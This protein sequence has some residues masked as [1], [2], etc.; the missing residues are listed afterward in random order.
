M[1]LDRVDQRIDTPVLGGDGLDHRRAPVARAGELEHPLQVVDGR[2]HPVAIGLVHHEH[3][4]DLEQASLGRLHAVAPAGGDDDERGVGRPCDPDLHLA[5]PDHRGIG[6]GSRLLHAAIDT[7]RADG[8][9]RATMWLNATAD[10]LRAFLADQGWAPDG[11]SRQLD[12]Y[13]D[14]AVV[15]KQVRLHTAV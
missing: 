5:D 8:F 12:L 13:G 14:G 7:L 2:G 11:G 4:T 3:V 10:D 15:V 1:A 6:H 9:Q